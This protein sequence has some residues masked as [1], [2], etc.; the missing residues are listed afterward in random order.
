MKIFQFQNDIYLYG[1][2]AIPVFILIW[3]ILR[4]S[5]RNEIAKFG[6]SNLVQKL[7]P[8]VSSSKKNWKFSLLLFAFASMIIT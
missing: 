1:L 4:R 2:L 3:V 5:Y 7:M 6:N 8:Q